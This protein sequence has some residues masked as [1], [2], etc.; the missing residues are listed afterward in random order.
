MP[1]QRSNYL[2]TL[3]LFTFTV[4]AMGYLHID[5]LY[6]NQTILLFKECYALEKV[7]GTSAHVRFAASAV[8]LEFF[9]GG[10]S[11]T[12]FVA[13]FDK[14]ALLAGFAAIGEPNIVVYGEAYGGSCQAMKNTYGSELR[15]IVFD[16]AINDMFVDVPT[17]EK[18][19]QGL[20]LEVVPYTRVPTNVQ[21]LDELRDKPSEVAHRRGCGTDKPREGIV[22]RPLIELHG[23]NGERIIAK[24][25]GAAFEERKTVQKVQPPEKL[26][27]LAQADA[28]AEEWVTEMRLTHVLDKLPQGLGLEATKQ[29]I[30]AMIE[31]VTR[32]AA[33]EIVDSREARNAIGKRAAKLFKERICK[34]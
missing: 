26:V 22:L 10:V 27:V 20:G 2:L 34:L 32:E 17:M 18:L 6:K 16:I 1:E 14:E 4:G 9:P 19:A 23:N 25:K 31:D 24:H 29:V 7:H 8:D 15:F 28:I 12:N 30:N 33:G 5:N 21:V 3:A 13:L 11:R